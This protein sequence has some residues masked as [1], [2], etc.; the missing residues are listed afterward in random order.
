MPFINIGCFLVLYKA[1]ISAWPIILLWR[2]GRGREPWERS[3][4][5]GV[6]D[7]EWHLHHSPS[8]VPPRSSGRIK[9]GATTVE[10]KRG[11]GLDF[12]LCGS[13]PWGAAAFLLCSFILLLKCF[14]RSP[15]PAS[16]LSRSKICVTPT[17]YLNLEGQFTQKCKFCHHLLILKYFQTCMNV[18]V[19]LNTKEDILK[20]V[21]NRAVRGYHWLP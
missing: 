17:Q 4:A 10:E 21:G 6:N 9:G 12:S 16:I 8:R 13:R 3:E 2:V 11:L 19:L 15:V 18:F 14:K 20:N 1:H 5:V 7:N